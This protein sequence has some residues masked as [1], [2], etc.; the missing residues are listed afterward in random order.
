MLAGRYRRLGVK[1]FAFLDNGSDDGTFEWLPEQEDTDLYRCFEKY[2]TAVEEGWI[3]RT[4]S[5]YGFD[6]RLI[7]TDSDEL[8]V[9]EGMETTL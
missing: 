5:Y 9:Y 7:L 3:N 8:V 1:G 4:A 6:S 2:R